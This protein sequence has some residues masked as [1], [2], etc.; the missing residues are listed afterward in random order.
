[1]F[2]VPDKD[3]GELVFVEFDFASSIAT[4]VLLYKESLDVHL[5][6]TVFMGPAST[7]T[8]QSRGITIYESYTIG[9]SETFEISSSVVAKTRLNGAAFPS[10]I[11]SNSSCMKD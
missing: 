1:M 5:P 7:N 8:I 6:T 3:V 2:R 11:D 10:I 4:G 9:S